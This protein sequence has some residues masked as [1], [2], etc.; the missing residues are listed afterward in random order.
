MNGKDDMP[1]S[2]GTPA[3]SV[4]VPVFNEASH[5]GT[6]LAMM[7]DQEV[8]AG[9]EILVID[10][11]S[12]D[13]TREIVGNVSARDP[14]IRILDNPARQIPIALNIGLRAAQGSYVARMDAHTLYPAGYL[15]AGLTRLKA[16]DVEWVSGPA[17]A[18]GVGRWS[19]RVAMALNTPMG[20]GGAVFRR[21]G[22]ER[23][24]DSGFTG[25]M[26]RRTLENLNGWD[27]GWL[28]NED[29]ELAARV[30][31]AGGR[32]VCLPEMAAA[33]TPR[34]SLSSLA[35]Q[36]WRYGQYRAK[37][38]RRHPT[39]MRPSHVLPPAFTLITALAFLPGPYSWLPRAGTAV[40]IAAAVMI[41]GR[42]VSRGRPPVDSAL[43]PAIFAVMHLAWG[44]G[45]L[46][47][48]ARFGPSF[49]ALAHL[50]RTATNRSSATLSEVRDRDRPA[51]A[52]T[53]DVG[54]VG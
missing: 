28:V 19:R 13:G 23:D 21:L 1:Q 22:P 45:F 50:A 24:V 30:R 53:T 37:T 52:A 40:W 7:C 25:I 11:G 43:L 15:A 18:T 26:R 54:R 42:E 48:C 34:D 12:T 51:G 17:L 41:A 16:G 44:A 32:I 39:S 47:G 33:Y 35:R 46:A 27:E 3:V 29:G 4:L 36:Y 38:C 10:G 5:I 2:S 14:R 9:L 6:T 8:S 49:G 31:A 20:I